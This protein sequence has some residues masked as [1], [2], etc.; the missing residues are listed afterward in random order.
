MDIYIKGI[1]HSASVTQAVKVNTEIHNMWM[2]CERT[3]SWIC[4]NLRS[5]YMCNLRMRQTSTVSHTSL[6]EDTRRWALVPNS[7]SMSASSIMTY[8]KPRLQQVWRATT[9]RSWLRRIT[10]KHDT[11]GIGV[12]SSR[13]VGTKKMRLATGLSLYELSHL[14]EKT[15]VSYH[16]T[17]CTMK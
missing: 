16:V 12:C 10:S 3:R 9:P 13:L 6:Y 8:Q 2:Y 14:W 7:F 5:V 17:T 11:Q 15:Q 1:V 4:M